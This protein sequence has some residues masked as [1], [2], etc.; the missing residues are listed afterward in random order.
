M[1]VEFGSNGISRNR[2]YQLQMQCHI[3]LLTGPLA[4]LPQH[5]E[6]STSEG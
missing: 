1:S 6:L 2:Q 5:V 4:C 3:H